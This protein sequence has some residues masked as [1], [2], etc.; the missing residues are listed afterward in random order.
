MAGC[1]LVHLSSGR[2]AAINS[3]AIG[4][5]SSVVCLCVCLSVG[6]IREFCKNGET[7]QDVD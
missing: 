1:A 4:G 5:G 6:H 3:I 7:D 2:I